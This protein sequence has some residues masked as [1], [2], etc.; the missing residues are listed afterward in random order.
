[1]PRLSKEKKELILGKVYPFLMDRP[2]TAKKYKIVSD[3]LQSIL[4]TKSN[5][6]TRRKKYLDELQ[7]CF[8]KLTSQSTDLIETRQKLKQVRNDLER[9]SR[10]RC[11]IQDKLIEAE[12]QNS[13]YSEYK[14]RFEEQRKCCTRSEQDYGILL[15]ENDTL[16]SRITALKKENK[17]LKDLQTKI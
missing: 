6:G 13:L 15:R 14:A 9:Q 5:N 2:D 16:I 4:K 11:E 3:I 12:Y 7:N 10:K 1:M 8:Q 17:A